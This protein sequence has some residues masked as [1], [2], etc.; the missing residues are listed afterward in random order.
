MLPLVQ[1]N[2]YFVELG[3]YEDECLIRQGQKYTTHKM[4]FIDVKML[5]NIE[6]AN[7]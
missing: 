6:Y 4:N 1:L 3:S 5:F 7:V 2:L